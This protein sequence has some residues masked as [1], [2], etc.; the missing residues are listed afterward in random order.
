MDFP[1]SWLASSPRKALRSESADRR[2]GR[3]LRAV[4]LST[5]QAHND[6]SEP[7]RASLKDAASSRRHELTP[8][9]QIYAGRGR[10]WR[11]GAI[12]RGH[13]LSKVGIR[14]FIRLKISRRSSICLRSPPPPRPL[15]VPLSPL[16]RPFN[17]RPRR[18]I[19]ADSWRGVGAALL[20]DPH[21]RRRYGP[22]SHAYDQ[23]VEYPASLCA[24]RE[25]SP[26]PEPV[27]LATSLPGAER[28]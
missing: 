28:P 4:A 21:H 27:R 12:T 7:H 5:R 17:G 16:T 26:V 6:G 19:W 14:A 8:T 9:D 23:P 15:K 13:D 22:E 25:A 24:W 11:K 20:H 10:D 1:R 18:R 2:G 3:Y